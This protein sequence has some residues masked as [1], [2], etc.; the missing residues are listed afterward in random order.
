MTMPAVPGGG[1]REEGAFK[2]REPERNGWRQYCRLGTPPLQKAFHLLILTLRW[3][4]FFHIYIWVKCTDSA[5][6]YCRPGLFQPVDPP[7]PGSEEY[8]Q[9]STETRI[10]VVGRIIIPFMQCERYSR[11]RY[12]PPSLVL[13]YLKLENCKIDEKVAVSRGGGDEAFWRSRKIKLCRR[14]QQMKGTDAASHKDSLHA[15]VQPSAMN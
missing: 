1:K 5:I 15:C 10:L 14:Y 11:R 13:S 7:P 3:R 8:W 2:P 12:P 9:R 6:H 4:V